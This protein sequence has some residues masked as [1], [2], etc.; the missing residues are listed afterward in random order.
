MPPLMWN[1][2]WP[3]TAPIATRW[4]C[5]RRSSTES[6]W[7]LAARGSGSKQWIVARGNL[8]S[9]V[10]VSVPWWAPISRMVRAFT[11]M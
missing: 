5:A 3:F 6:A 4:R 9:I 11:P 1:S 7:I 2:A 8:A 10:R